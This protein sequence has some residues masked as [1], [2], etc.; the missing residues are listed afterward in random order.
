ME[1]V[2]TIPGVGAASIDSLSER[3]YSVIQGTTLLLAVIFVGINL[4]TDLAYAFLDPRVKAT[5]GPG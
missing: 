4:L 5:E 1:T 3:D 2:F